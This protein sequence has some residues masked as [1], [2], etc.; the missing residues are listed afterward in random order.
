[1]W[2]GKVSDNVGSDEPE[3]EVKYIGAMHG[4]ELTGLENCIKLIDTLL[5]GYGVDAELTE[6]VNDYEIYILPLMNPD[7]RNV[8]TLGQRFNANGQDLNRDFPDRCWDSTN[9][10]AGRE[11]ETAHVMDFTAARNF[12]ISANFH[13]GEVVANYPWDSNYNG[14]CVLA[15]SGKRFVLS[16]CSGLRARKSDD[17]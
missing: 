13:G 17:V 2:V 14:Q 1:M 16:D 15:E 4:D 10:A 6:M 3:I 5:T 8:G 12:V 11:I 7:G 9:T